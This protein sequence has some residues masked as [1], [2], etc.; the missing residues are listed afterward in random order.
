MARAVGSLEVQVRWAW[1]DQGVRVAGLVGV[2][3]PLFRQDSS[4]CRIKAQETTQLSRGG[5]LPVPRKPLGAWPRSNPQGPGLLWQGRCLSCCG[6]WRGHLPVCPCAD[7]ASCVWDGVGGH[8]LTSL[9]GSATGHPATLEARSPDPAPTGDA[10][11]DA[12]GRPAAA[13]Q[14]HH[15][16]RPAAGPAEPAAAR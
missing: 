3:E 12:H 16:D 6:T 14:P 5:P 2:V 1:E 9:P 11:T 8:V 10:D 7:P 4:T 15:A 13:S